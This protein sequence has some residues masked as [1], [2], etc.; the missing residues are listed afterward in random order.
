[1]KGRVMRERGN[2]L[3][4]PIGKDHF[5]QVRPVS[6]PVSAEMADVVGRASPVLRCESTLVK[7]S[8]EMRL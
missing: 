2:V 7:Q 4:T 6:Q 3:T 1:V 8:R 5:R